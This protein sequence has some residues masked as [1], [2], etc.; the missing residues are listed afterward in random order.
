MND[1][2]VGHPPESWLL[3]EPKGEGAIEG[4][5]VDAGIVLADVAI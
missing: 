1:K 2:R 5:E 3:I 4:H